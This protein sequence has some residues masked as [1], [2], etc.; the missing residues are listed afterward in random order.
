M[1]EFNLYDAFNFLVKLGEYSES[2][3]V[4]KS[5]AQNVVK[6]LVL[7]TLDCLNGS[8]LEKEF[9]LK[10]ECKC[11]SKKKKVEEDIVPKYSISP[12]SS[13]IENVSY[14]P[15]KEEFTL[16]T[17]EGSAYVYKNVPEELWDDLLDEYNSGQSIGDF[18]N[19]YIKGQYDRLY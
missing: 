1:K 11:E 8:D 19:E 17:Q 16:I 10:N 4:K 13:W 3:L 14:D 15:T 2:G 7:H 5:D 6:S 18:Y 9:D 12:D